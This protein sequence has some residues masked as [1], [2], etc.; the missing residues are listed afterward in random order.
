MFEVHLKPL[1][2]KKKKKRRYPNHST[3]SISASCFCLFAVF[4]QKKRLTNQTMWSPNPKMDI[5]IYHSSSLEDS[6]LRYFP[7]GYLTNFIPSAFYLFFKKK[8]GY[9]DTISH[10]NP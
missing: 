2:K 1:E 5:S 9:S 3:N 10:N 7:C 4:L 8:C 6:E